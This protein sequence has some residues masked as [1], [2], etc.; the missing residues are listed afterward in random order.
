MISEIKLEAKTAMED[1]R[2]STKGEVYFCEDGKLLDECV[3]E[4]V[5]VCASRVCIC[6]SVWG[7]IF[8]SPLSSPSSFQ[9]FSCPAE[10]SDFQV[11]R[12]PFNPLISG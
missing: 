10:K 9:I 6:T 12:S 1:R 8:P 7:G 11:W 3:Y 2:H 4:C 5:C